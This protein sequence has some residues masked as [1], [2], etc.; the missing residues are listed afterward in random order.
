MSSYIDLFLK[1]E[2]T[3]IPR[4]IHKYAGSYYNNGLCNGATWLFVLWCC[5]HLLFDWFLKAFLRKVK[6]KEYI[7]DRLAHSLWYL[8]YYGTALFYCGATIFQNEMELFNFKKMHVP[9]SSNLPNTLIIGY[10]LMSTFYLHSSVWEGLKNGRVLSMIAYLLLTLFLIVSYILR[11]VEISFTLTSLISIAQILVEIIRITT[12]LS[13]QDIF[14]VNIFLSTLLCICVV[15]Y[16][17]VYLF[18]IPLTFIIPMGLKIVSDYPDTL[19]RMLILINASWLFIEVYNSVAYKLIYHWIFHSD[20]AEKICNMI[21][22]S[23]F[24]PRDDVAFHLENYRQEVRAKEAEMMSLRKPKNKS[25]LIQTLKCM[26]AIKRKLSE[27]RLSENSSD[28]D[29]SEKSGDSD[30][31]LRENED[32]EDR[33]LD[34]DDEES[35][36]DVDDSMGSEEQS[37][38]SEKSSKKDQ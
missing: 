16:V 31:K 14:F 7:S 9:S 5:L 26:V 23:L 1:T 13:N 3:C 33:E 21:D 15:I 22:C 38:C 4:L 11:I 17:T 35:D 20:D 34:S 27:K 2:L 8:G 6:Y 37:E 36:T 18:I 12:V 30:A 24:E 10:T 28:S 32:N 29:D 19:L 25:M